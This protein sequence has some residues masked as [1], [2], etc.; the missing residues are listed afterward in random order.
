MTTPSDR[1]AQYRTALLE[2]VDRY[3]AER[4]GAQRQ[5]V[6]DQVQAVADAVLAAPLS[7]AL[8][9]ALGARADRRRAAGLMTALVEL[10]ALS[11]RRL[12]SG[13]DGQDE[14]SV[15][16]LTL[17]AADG[18]YA[19]G[20]LALL[21]FADS[22]GRHSGE[23]LAILDALATRIWEGAMSEG[24]FGDWAGVAG[25]LGRTAGS[26][27][28]LAAGRA[29]VVEV[30]AELGESLTLRWSGDASRPEIAGVVNRA[31]FTEDERVRLLALSG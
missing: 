18:L 16:P 9:D 19:L 25:R 28:A 17:N 1:L 31:P 8:A 4:T 23:T 13:A 24:P 7:L 22:L 2:D 11:L 3:I 12:C 29:E 27:A 20:H 15:Q 21:D 26:A 6:R 30:L 14:P 10:A 5:M